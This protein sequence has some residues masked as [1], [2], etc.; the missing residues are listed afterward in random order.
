[1][2]KKVSLYLLI[3]GIA[4]MMGTVSS[5]QIFAEKKDDSDKKFEQI[6]KKIEKLSENQEEMIDTLKFI[7]FRVQ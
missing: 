4:F 1:M 3:A 5:S 2:W 7:R 6:L